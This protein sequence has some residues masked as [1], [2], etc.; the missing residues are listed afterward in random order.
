MA[1]AMLALFAWWEREF[2]G[3]PWLAFILIAVSALTKGPVGIVLP[4]GI[5]SLFC[6]MR[7]G[8]GIRAIGPIA[9][10][11]ILLALAAGVVVSTWYVLGYLERG[12]EFIAKIRYENIERFTSTMQDEP[13]KHSIWYLVGMLFVG[14]IPWSCFWLSPGVQA[15]RK[16]GKAC[17]KRV[18]VV[19]WYRSLPDLYQF[20]VV[21]SLSVVIFFCIP[22]SKRSVYLLPAFPFFALLLERSLRE[23]FETRPR[24]T[25][26][27]THSLVSLS[28]VIVITTFALMVTPVK[29]VVLTFAAFTT[30]MSALKLGSV[31]LLVVACFWGLSRECRQIWD[32]ARNRIGLTVIWAVVLISFFSYDTVASQ[33]SVREW[34]KSPEFTASVRPESHQRMYSF[35]TEAYG[36]SFYLRKPFFRVPN[37][38]RPG[39]IVFLERR[40]LPELAAL[41]QYQLVELA[42]YSSGLAKPGR[43]I[44]VVEVSK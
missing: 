2:R 23:W 25:R 1:G 14:L 38:P 26:F 21:A 22:S 29:G 4:I 3:V 8:R 36:A 41:A 24:V 17:F 18:F 16:N 15:L 34:V 20:S 42:H 13:H 9:L 40:K 27:V 37:T 10:R 32:D 44:V 43:D 39:S 30:S 7:S 31:C 33:L 5:F 28:I 6:W 35:G 19:E 12:A 11:G